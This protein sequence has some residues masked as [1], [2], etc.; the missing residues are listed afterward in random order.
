MR[1][2]HQSNNLQ[3]ETR[4]TEPADVDRSERLAV[5]TKPKLISL[6]FDVFICM[7]Y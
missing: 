5:L 3:E 2:W 6:V 4:S 7:Y 1:D